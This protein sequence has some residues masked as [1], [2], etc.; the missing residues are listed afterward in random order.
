MTLI[1]EILSN[2]F[3]VVGIN[4]GFKRSAALG[5]STALRR[6]IPPDPA[7]KDNAYTKADL[8]Y[9][10]GVSGI[11]DLKLKSKQ[12]GAIMGSFQDI[13]VNAVRSITS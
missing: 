12:M 5:L 2:C 6:R 9:T 7:A 11:I 3:V 1:F 4:W 13:L 10:T 8:S